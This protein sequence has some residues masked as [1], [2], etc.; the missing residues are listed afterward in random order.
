MMMMDIRVTEV[1]HISGTEV[2]HIR[3]TEVIHIRGTEVNHIRGTEV[4]HI[5]GK[6]VHH[7]CQALSNYVNT[8]MHIWHHEPFQQL[9]E[10]NKNILQVTLNR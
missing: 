4:N 2:N 5:R 10:K 1:N 3:G 8:A 9:Y 7:N 6:E